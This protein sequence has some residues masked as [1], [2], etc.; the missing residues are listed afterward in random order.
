MILLVIEIPP[1]EL[2]CLLSLKRLRL[3]AQ[4]SECSS[5]SLWM[6]SVGGLRCSLTSN[7]SMN[8]KIQVNRPDYINIVKTKP[9]KHCFS[10]FQLQGTDWWPNNTDSNLM[11]LQNNCKQKCP[12]IWTLVKQSAKL[13]KWPFWF[14]NYSKLWF[15]NVFVPFHVNSYHFLNERKL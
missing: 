14:L 9:T 7:E 1:A 6:E 13:L 12:E 5:E 15:L 8:D 2:R 10:H 11:I 4:W 3:L